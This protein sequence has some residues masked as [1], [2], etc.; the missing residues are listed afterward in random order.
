MADK[1]SRKSD[2]NHIDYDAKHDLKL[3]KMIRMQKSKREIQAVIPISDE[4]LRIKHGEVQQI[5]ER[6]YKCDGLYPSFGKI[7]FEEQGIGIPI[8]RLGETDF[9]EGDEFDI[10]VNQ[11][12]NTIVLKKIEIR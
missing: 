10:V 6:F 2:L 12:E 8:S 9:Q 5:D 4:M 7:M 3:Y 11:E 1:S